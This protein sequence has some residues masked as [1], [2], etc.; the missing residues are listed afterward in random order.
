MLDFGSLTMTEII[1]L[2]NKLQ[3][4]LVRRFERPMALVFS[5]IVG[6]TP[7]FARFG[8]GAGRQLQQ[9]HVDLFNGCIGSRGGRLV[10][11]V[12][13]GIFMVFDTVPD[14]VDCVIDFQRQMA[15]ANEDRSHPHQLRV[16]I[17]I[18]WGMVLTDGTAVS[19]EAVNLCARVAGS[20]AAGEVRVTRP[21]FQELDRKHR[22]SCRALG[23]TTLRG[24]DQPVELL[25]LDWRDPTTF[26]RS[27]LVEETQ[28]RIELPQQ[29]VVTFGRLL[30]HAGSRAND[31]V[32]HHP[33]PDV[34]RQ[35]SRWHFELRRFEN[36][37][38]L[39]ALSESMTTVDG[40]PVARGAVHPVRAGSRIGVADLLHV[41]LLGA[42]P[43]ELDE[44]EHSTMLRVGGRR[45]GHTEFGSPDFD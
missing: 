10:D 43:A 21:V 2:Q 17:G 1:R 40:L 31:I 19:G 7:Y 14:A 32:L 16:H 29:D 24:I 8:D 27:V 28:E 33:D 15:R 20:T 37:V 13:D 9:L 4:E 30:N 35:V 23:L 42:E 3:Q 11:T 26:P 12:G 22:L 44:D 34:L 18:H 45:P 38:R 25:V 5:D 39:L 6:S 36:G 41:R